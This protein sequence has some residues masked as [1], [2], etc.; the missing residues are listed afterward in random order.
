M[1]ALTV[2]STSNLFFVKNDNVLYKK[3]KYVPFYS[4][5]HVRPRMRHMA[6]TKPHAGIF[7]C[8]SS[9]QVPIRMHVLRYTYHLSIV[10]E[11]QA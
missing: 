3:K 11:F 1:H 7:P 5:S 9:W 2:S 10:G 8:I 6:V 4:L